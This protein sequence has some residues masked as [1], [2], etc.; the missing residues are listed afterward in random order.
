MSAREQK[1]FDFKRRERTLSWA[2]TLK[3]IQ[4]ESLK[5]PTP[6]R[7]YEVFESD[8]KSYFALCQIAN[9]KK[10]N[11]QQKE[12]ARSLLFT[13]RTKLE[14]AIQHSLESFY[15][16][17]TIQPYLPKAGSFFT[18]SKK[19]GVSLRFALTSCVPSKL[20]GNLCYAHDGMDAMPH[21]IIKG[22][23]NSFIASK[24]ENERRFFVGAFKDFVEL[25]C[26]QIVKKSFSEVSR[27]EWNRQPRIRFSH[28]GEIA[29]FPN[30]ANYLSQII[31]Q[32]SKNEITQVVYTRHPNAAL[33]SENFLI[34][35]TIDSSSRNRRKFSESRMNIVGSSFDG[36]LERDAKINFLEHHG[37]IHLAGSD[38]QD[39]ICIVSDAR[40]GF[41]S[42]D[43]A[44]C[45]KCFEK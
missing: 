9:A 14:D 32:K 36:V 38:E 11:C 5:D 42:C 27:L 20:C 26:E 18:V 25:S 8:L 31:A 41:R 2:K 30:F 40:N 37:K 21:S 43:E 4:K 34:N 17:G 35:F 10:V 29:N 15:S 12:V 44:R 16:G 33:L 19:Q 39:T 7:I 45:T 3:N 24:Y 28:V 22:C 6:K 23:I 13:V 1:S